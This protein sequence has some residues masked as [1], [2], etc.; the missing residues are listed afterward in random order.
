MRKIFWS[1]V[2]EVLC[3]YT[4]AELSISDI[5]TKKIM[6]GEY[7][8]LIENFAIRICEINAIDYNFPKNDCREYVV[9]RTDKCVSKNNIKLPKSITNRN[10]VDG[11]LARYLMCSTPPPVYAGASERNNIPIRTSSMLEALSGNFMKECQKDGTLTV[12]YTNPISCASKSIEELKE[13]CLEVDRP[14]LSKKISCGDLFSDMQ[15]CKDKIKLKYPVL[16]NKEGSTQI[17]KDFIWC[18]IRDV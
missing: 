9:S 10:Q 8:N 2:F 7:I 18:L 14:K 15:V 16:V 1:M 13:K 11:Y 17:A 6:R 3:S 12:E 4:H 5:G